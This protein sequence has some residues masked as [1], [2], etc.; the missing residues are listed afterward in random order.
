MASINE[1]SFDENNISVLR[2]QTQQNLREIER[3][4]GFLGFVTGL[5]KGI[6]ETLEKFEQ[7]GHQQKTMLRDLY[8][9]E[10]EPESLTDPASSIN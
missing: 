3:H 9:G 6:D 8:S 7:V 2:E 4:R 5:L 10:S 1:R